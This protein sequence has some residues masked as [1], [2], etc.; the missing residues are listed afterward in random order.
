MLLDVV[1]IMTPFSGTNFPCQASIH[2]CG[3]Y[4]TEITY[5]EEKFMM[6]LGFRYFSP[7]WWRGRVRQNRSHH[8]RQKADTKIPLLSGPPVCGTGQLPF[9]IVLHLSSLETS[10]MCLHFL[11]GASESTQ[12]DKIKQ[13]EFDD[14]CQSCENVIL[15][16]KGCK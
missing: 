1:S 10:E 8:G 13:H 16:A 3:K 14:E 2:C 9:Q 7:S 6:A 11:L 4:P 12:V 5:R 15:K